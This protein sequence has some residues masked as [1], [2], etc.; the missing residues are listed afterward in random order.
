MKKNLLLMIGLLVFCS[1]SIAQEFKPV[2]VYGG[3]QFAH[4]QPNANGNGWNVGVTGNLTV[5]SESR[6]T[7]VA[8]TNP[9]HRSTPTWSGQPSRSARSA[10]RPL[11]M[12]YSEVPMP[13]G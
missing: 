8:T 5:P 7:S 3:Y 13:M 11:H 10:S 2:E 6:A 9:G 12:R 1:S 4:A